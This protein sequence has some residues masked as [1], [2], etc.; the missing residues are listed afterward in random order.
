MR[1]DNERIKRQNG[2]EAIIA[3][4]QFDSTAE[5]VAELGEVSALRLIN[6]AYREFIRTMAAREL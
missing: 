6:I 5:A 4:R 2:R 3:V 1:V